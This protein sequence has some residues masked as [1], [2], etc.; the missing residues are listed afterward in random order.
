MG[1]IGNEATRSPLAL[2]V[3]IKPASKLK[4][5]PL[6]AIAAAYTSHEAP[7]QVVEVLLSAL[8]HRGTGKTVY[9]ANADSA[10]GY[11]SNR[12]ASEHATQSPKAVI[13]VD[14]SFYQ[15]KNSVKFALA[16]LMKGALKTRV[17]RVMCEPGGFAVMFY[18]RGNMLGFR[19]PNGLKPLYFGMNRRLTA[20]ASERKALWK[21]GLTTTNRVP[22]GRLCTAGRRGISQSPLFQFRRPREKQITLD[23]AKTQL[24]RLLRRSIKRITEG[25]GNV[26]VAFSGGLDS[27]ITAQL[28]RSVSKVELISVGLKD[29]AELLTVEKYA[30]QL[31]LPVTQEAFEPDSMEDYVRRIVWLIEEPN[32]MKVSVAIP[33]H[34]AA[35]LAAKR[36]LKLMLCGQG[37]DELYGGYYKYARILDTKG[38]NALR[39]ALHRSIIEAA[40]VNYERDE[41]ATAPFGI[42]LRTPFADL[43]IIRFSLTI[44]LAFK[45]REGNDLTRKWVLR[46][47]AKD[48]GI[49]DDIA[50]KRKK[51]IQ[52]GTGVE[53]AIIKL[54][55]RKSPTVE[56]YLAKVH[57]EMKEMESMP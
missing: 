13:A 46:A 56:S 36:G 12:D 30:R 3:H 47:S 5:R 27:A 55:K 49:P 23:E 14:G 17:S 42:E 28:A 48:L 54:A 4:R 7:D 26:A 11:S 50:W 21:I 45:V 24:G 40:E 53:N 33:L 22:P 9:L 38:R 2:V 6:G 32:L 31:N 10:I 1:R 18:R 29:S 52:H 51:A 19:D 20:F 57:A 15:R 35:R 25:V 37:S 34:W 43:D 41:Q 39:I 44:P 8:K 16:S